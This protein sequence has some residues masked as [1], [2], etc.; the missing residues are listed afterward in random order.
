MTKN[1]FVEMTEQ[2][3]K[4]YERVPVVNGTLTACACKVLAEKMMAKAIREK[5]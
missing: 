1:A 2:Q 5:K 3:A 4:H